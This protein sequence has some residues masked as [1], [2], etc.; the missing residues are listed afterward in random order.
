[1]EAKISSTGILEV[2][3]AGSSQ[4]SISI[5]SK[6]WFPDGVGHTNLTLWSE[7]TQKAVLFPLPAD[8]V[9]PEISTDHRQILFRRDTSE[10][11]SELWVIDTNGQNGKR[12]VTLRY[13]ETAAR[14]AADLAKYVVAISLDYDW[15]PNTDKIFYSVDVTYGEEGPTIFDKFVLV[16]V[17]SGKA[18]PLANPS[19]IS[20]YTF[21]PDGNQMAV[22]TENDLRMVSTQNGRVLFTTQASLRNPI[23]SPDGK[24]IVDFIDEGILRINAQ[25]GQQ[26]IIPFQ[27]TTMEGAPAFEGPVFTP[28]P[29]FEWVGNSTLLMPSLVSDKR[30]TYRSEETDPNGWT[31]KVWRVDLAEGTAHPSA[32]F[33]GDPD[34]VVLSRDGNRLAYFKIELSDSPASLSLTRLPGSLYLADLNTGQ[35]LETVTDGPFDAW[36]P[37]LTRY[38][39]TR[40]REAQTKTS[41]K[42]TEIFLGKIGEEPIS[43]GNVEGSPLR[44]KWLDN[45]RLEIVIGSCAI[46]GY[47][48]LALVSLGPPVKITTIVP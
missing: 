45:K 14:Y 7:D 37:D 38:V 40:E 47:Q 18:I 25:N 11:Q 10:N 33:S 13:D 17:N 1:M 6:F 20:D 26:Q 43:L 8:A 34:S 5:Y 48:M 21:A 9:G 22:M 36:S 19:Q 24:Y 39:Y 3:Y 41:Q 32:T 27:Y 31:F 29:Y 35:I 23:Y 15:I 4:S 16:D 44:F 30:N 28:L 12:L 42:I 2:I 46:R